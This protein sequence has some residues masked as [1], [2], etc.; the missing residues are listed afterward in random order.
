MVPVTWGEA[1]DNKMVYKKNGEAVLNAKPICNS[2]H[3]YIKA[4]SDKVS[5]K[6][7]L[8]LVL[9]AYAYPK[10]DGPQPTA[11]D[12]ELALAALALLDAQAKDA[13]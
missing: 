1:K 5:E 4:T 13:G 12:R 8:E 7:A 6:K 9:K 11:S 2:W 3:Q 10:E